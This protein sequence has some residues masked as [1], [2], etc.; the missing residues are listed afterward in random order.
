MPS[1]I[2]VQTKT[3]RRKR[4]T[5]QQK[6][7]TQV[8]KALKKVVIAPLPNTRR[9]YNNRIKNRMN[10]MI[11]RNRK[12]MTLSTSNYK[13]KNIIP[14]NIITPEGMSFLKCAFAPPD[15]ADTG[16][17]GVP[18]SFRGQSLLKKHRYT[19]PHTFASTN[20]HYILVLPTPGYAYWSATTLPGA[21]LTAASQFYGVQFSDS[22]SLFGN[23]VT[24][25]AD[26][27]N[28]YRYISNHFELKSTTNMMTYSGAVSAFKVP[29]RLV[30]RSSATP[31]DLWT[32]TGVNG[33]T[34]TKANIYSDSYQKGIYA[35]CYN[36]APDFEFQPIIES[37]TAVIPHIVG[38]ADWGQLVGVNNIPGFQNDFECLLIK[39][40]GL[41]ADVSAVIQV[42]T[43]VEYKVNPNAQIYDY[44][45]YSPM[46]DAL[47]LRAYREMILALPIAVPAGENSNFWQ[48]CLTIL[49]TISGFAANVPG[50]YGLVARGVN[51][52]TT[53]IQQLT[54]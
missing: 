1:S 33:T 3:F 13:P 25:A 4:P 32:I 54:I 26:I 38:P 47:A 20:D 27:V 17:K 28:E 22:V 9:T 39:I 36:A 45:T 19:Q 49:R 2:V 5:K 41:T 52:A 24:T 29:I 7:K 37:T 35:G 40:T 6:I 10:R 23:S 42:W 46:E 8:N 30:Q 12:N 31:E 48:R 21:P 11:R 15:F 51:L 44:Q 18:D 14:K 34:S 53:G 16:V 50:P 43:C